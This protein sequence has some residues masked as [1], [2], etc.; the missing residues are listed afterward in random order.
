M[1]LKKAIGPDKISV[2]I[3][4]NINP[5]LSSI[6]AKLFYRC[7]EENFFPNLW[8]VSIV[9]PVFK[10]A[11]KRSSPSQCKPINLL[12]VI[13]KLFEAKNKKFLEHLDKNNFLSDKEYRFKSVRSTADVLIL[14]WF[15]YLIF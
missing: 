5:K 13:S 11:G 1:S 7:F 9:C 6:L 10:N 15:K 8:K 4:K 12:S 14:R 2:I 3:L